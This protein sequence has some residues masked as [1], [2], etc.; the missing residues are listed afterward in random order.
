[1]KNFILI[2]IFLFYAA[3]LYAQD[4]TKSLAYKNN[5]P[6]RSITLFYQPD[7]SYRI[8]QQ[9]NLIR[10]ANAGDPLAQH[11]L[12]IRYL[13]GEGVEADT[14]KA[15]KWIKSAAEHGVTAAKYNYAILLINGWGTDWNPFKAFNLFKEAAEEG[16]PQAQYAVGLLYTDN[17]I[18]KRN[19]GKAYNWISKSAYTGNEDALKT[20]KEIK[21][22][23]PD[24]KIDTTTANLS[25]KDSSTGDNVN[26]LKSSLGLV[27]IDFEDVLD[28][29]PEVTGKRLLEDLTHSGYTLL[30]DSIKNILTDTNF[31]AISYYIP[32]INEAADYGSPE[33]LTFLG[34]LYET[35]I[36]YK[37]DLLTA[38]EYYLR[39]VRL[40]SPTAP[41]LL[42]R[43]QKAGK[44]FPML[45]NETDVNN[46]IALF[47]WY[48][49]EITGYD[50]QITAD[51]A[52]KLLE[53]SANQNF[54]PA[55][56][57]Y[58]SYFYSSRQSKPEIEKAFAI[59]SNA[60][61]LG[62]KEAAIRINTVMIL[63]QLPSSR[64][65]DKIKDLLLTIEK[66]S[67][68][69]QA[70]IA[71]AYENGIGIEKNKARAV[72][73][74]RDAAQRGNRFAY[75]RLKNLYDEIRPSS[76]EFNVGNTR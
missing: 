51:D 71:Y 33:A 49:L 22:K 57:E 35:G 74:Y 19:W 11:E 36:Y 2:I 3:S 64:Y 28:S 45:K 67:I 75:E 25:Q 62:S 52:V 59:W 13:L 12:G 18:V 14:V 66:G 58:G 41:I 1:M 40:D 20:L 5:R 39:A 44:F 70:V 16:M 76:P 31:T 27:Y 38:I 60:E 72:Q 68:L 53:R 47:D 10:E 8:W 46:P 24:S 56:I 73:Y 63:D 48:G 69:S 61:K 34:K 42:Y 21:R 32:L 65:D 9:F 37:K 54:I 29:I 55:M 26:P 30:S 4:S 7:L 17:L 15:V 23:I 6:G 50:N 43:M